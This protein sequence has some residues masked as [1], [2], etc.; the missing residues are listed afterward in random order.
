LLIAIL[1]ALSP[2]S[3]G[4][5]AVYL[6]RH[7]QKQDDALTDTGK[8]QAKKL[9]TLLVD[10]GVTLVYRSQFQRTQDTADPLIDA[11]AARGIT[12]KTRR[13]DLADPL[14]MNPTDPSLLQDYAKTVLDDMKSQASGEIVLF[15]GH[16]TTVPAVI[17]AM[18]G[19][20]DIEIKATE[21]DHLFLVIPRSP[22]DL[23]PPGFFHLPHYAG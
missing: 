10:A 5:R 2:S 8:S 22:G 14:L 7:A 3:F 4:Q 19:P 17:K 9:A 11:L 12:V 1:M 15:V 6:V 20:S 18:G 23:R 13:V 16:D 21:F